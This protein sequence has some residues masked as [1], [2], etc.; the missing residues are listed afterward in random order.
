M[1]S[2]RPLHENPPLLT[3]VGR[4]RWIALAVGVAGLLACG[5]DA[6][7]HPSEVIQSYF[8]AWLY[9]LGLTIG[10]LTTLMIHHLTGGDWG[11][12]VRR[13]LEAALAPLLL[14]AVL[15][16]P[17]GIALPHL[18][19]WAIG[20]T[21]L[22]R[23]DGHSQEWFLNPT[24]FLLRAG[25]YLAIW[26][27]LSRLV[28]R[29]MRNTRPL[30][31]V[32]AVGLLTYALTAMFASVDW[33][34]SLMPLWYSTV[35]GLIFMTSQNLGAFALAIVCTTALHVA[36]ARNPGGLAPEGPQ[37][38]PDLTPE[39]CTDLGTLLFVYVLTWA[40]VAFSQ[41][42]I[43]WAGD[44][45]HETAWYLPRWH[46]SWRW[47][48]YT[49][50]TAQFG[51]PFVLLLFR[52]LKRDARAMLAI[53]AFVLSVHWLY[54]A[55]LVKP[56]VATAGVSLGWTD[57]AATVG[58]GGLWIWLFLRDLAVYPSFAHG[59]AEVSASAQPEENPGRA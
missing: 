23:L 39:R 7:S 16:V 8:I 44:L 45:P 41:W 13:W 28:V 36:L 55:W 24:F 5:L 9:F 15:F 49:I 20:R 26:L 52:A 59:G 4:R 3:R 51:I 43:V 56:S 30:T 33:V 57:C 18:F 2:P 10:S 22:T 37:V 29:G 42:I 21:G 1:S 32:C 17:V 11:L 14:L 35:V 34:D 12:P 25:L 31:T 53:A 40:Y 47:V 46:S 54:V 19:T 50:E 27:V 6:S 48:T 58:V 38:P